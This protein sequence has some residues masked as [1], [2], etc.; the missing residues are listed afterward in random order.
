M[1]VAPHLFQGW[2]ASCNST[3]SK[4]ALTPYPSDSVLNTAIAPYWW[5]IDVYH[6]SQT[7]PIN[8]TPKTASKKKQLQL[9][10]SHRL[11]RWQ[12]THDFPNKHKTN[13]LIAVVLIHAFS[14]C[15]NF[16]FKTLPAED[17]HPPNWRAFFFRLNK[18]MLGKSDFG[19]KKNVDSFRPH[20]F[21]KSID[22]FEGCYRCVDAHL[23]YLR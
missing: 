2:T 18:K 10:N 11:T 12:N 14:G 1:L 22:S 9:W 16:G 17:F 3:A 4:R 21:L 6:P 20:H 7:M 15:H 23:F 13:L 19:S 5:S 8:R